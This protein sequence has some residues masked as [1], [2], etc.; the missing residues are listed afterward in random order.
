MHFIGIKFT[1]S[2]IGGI[3]NAIA[4]ATTDVSFI[5]TPS[6]IDFYG[7][8]ELH[9]LRM[10]AVE[11]GVQRLALTPDAPSATSDY[12]LSDPQVLL[13]RTWLKAGDYTA[14]VE[15]GTFDDKIYIISYGH[16]AMG[17]IIESPQIAA[18][19]KELFELIK[20]G[21]KLLPEYCELPKLA[22]KP[23]HVTRMD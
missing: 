8:S 18:A 2:E 1:Y 23:A 17:L 6:G 12:K 20:R 10:L 5:H 21:Q 7:F 16:E 19:F 13:E 15:W 4:A 14:P 22:A 3:F 11:A 9:N